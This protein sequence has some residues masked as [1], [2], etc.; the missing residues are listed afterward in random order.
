M[1]E[2]MLHC[3]NLPRARTFLPSKSV[4]PAAPKINTND[5]AVGKGQFMTFHD[6]SFHSSPCCFEE[7]LQPKY[8]P[9]AQA[10]SS[11]GRISLERGSSDRKLC[12]AA[13]G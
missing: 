3:S 1:L 6:A 10:T 7:D 4:Q 2:K 13:E 9:A 8:V 5:G 12:W 11:T